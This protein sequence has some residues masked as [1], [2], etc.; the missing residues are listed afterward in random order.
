MLDF[1]V[2]ELEIQKGASI[3]KDCKI[4]SHTFICEGV[5][6]GDGV[7]VDSTSGFPDQ[8]TIEISGLSSEKPNEIG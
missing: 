7:F 5:H 2:G 6:I 3:G 4:S 8:G 1:R